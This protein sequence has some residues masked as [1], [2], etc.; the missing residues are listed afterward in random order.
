MIKLSDVVS[1]FFKEKELPFYLKPN[2]LDPRIFS[3]NET[4]PE[5]RRYFGFVSDRR[6]MICV[7]SSYFLESREDAWL[8]AVNPDCF[9]RF[10]E[11]LHAGLTSKSWIGPYSST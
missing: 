9:E 8:D 7:Y 5:A 10:H 3:I 4:Q 1:E 6:A 2:P 11:L